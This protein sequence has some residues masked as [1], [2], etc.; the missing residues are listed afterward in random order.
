MWNG[1]REPSPRPAGRALLLL[2]AAALAAAPAAAQGA[3]SP[4]VALSG[5]AVAGID[6]NGGNIQLLGGSIRPAGSG[7]QPMVVLQAYRLGY[8]LGDGTDV[9]S[10]AVN[11]AVGGGYFTSTG[12]VTGTVGYTFLDEERPGQ[13][14]EGGGGESGFTTAVNA[15]YWGSVPAL[16]GIAAYGWA[17]E[18][19]WTNLQA[20][21][22]VATGPSGTFSLGADGVWEGQLS[23][24]DDAY[25]SHSIGP[26]LR[27]SNDR[28]MGITLGAGW[29]EPR[30]GDGTWYARLG[31]AIYR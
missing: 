9:T 5:W 29:K 12:M 28:D 7:F 19:L 30:G 6:G 27:W 22:P 10:L 14:F 25:R 26:A 23:G 13:F 24:G 17:S 15:Q 3:A 1:E 18:Y 4:S 11:P 8:E 16:A 31:A 2:A 21:V 20:F